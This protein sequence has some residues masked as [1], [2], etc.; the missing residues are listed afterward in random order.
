M[1]EPLRVEGREG[2][3]RWLSAHHTEAREVRLYIRKKSSRKAGISLDEAVE[4]AI[5]YGWIDGG[6]KPVDGDEFLLRFTPRRRGTVWSLRNRGTA[7]R[8]MAE[9]RMEAPGLAVVEEARASGSWDNAYTSK[10]APEVPPDLEKALRNHKVA[11]V[12]FQSLNNTEK[13][14]YIFWVNGA[15]RPET[16]ARRIGSI[17]EK[18]SG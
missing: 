5:R 4:E 17:L 9:G 7:E 2:W 15:R 6:M 16:R 8:L 13:L 14:R 11:L 12:R 18:L 1:T 10:T 3:T